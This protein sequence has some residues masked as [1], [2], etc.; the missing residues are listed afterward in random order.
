MDE[1]FGIKLI[2]ELWKYLCYFGNINSC[3]KVLGDVHINHTFCC[4]DFGVVMICY[5]YYLW[6]ILILW[7]IYFTWCG[8][9]P[10]WIW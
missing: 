1:H 5:Y 3:E 6:F 2:H 10:R 9:R 4:T 8:L 7:R